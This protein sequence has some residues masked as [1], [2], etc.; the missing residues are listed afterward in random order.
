MIGSII[1]YSF[2]IVRVILNI[3]YSLLLCRP[4]YLLKSIISMYREKT[5]LFILTTLW[6]LQPGN[7]QYFYLPTDCH[8]VVFS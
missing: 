2:F 6:L 7:L 8:F 3:F 1:L 4:H 5:G